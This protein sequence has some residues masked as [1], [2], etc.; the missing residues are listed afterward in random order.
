MQY[1]ESLLGTAIHGDVG[2]PDDPRR[3]IV[4][5]FRVLFDPS[6]NKEDIVHDLSTSEGL[7]KLK[8]GGISLKEG[9]K[10]K[11]RVSFVVQHE[12]IAGVKFVNKVKKAVFSD[13]EDIMIGSFA[14]SS[15]P[16]AFEF[17]KFNYREAPSGMLFRGNICNYIILYSYSCCVYS[18]HV[19]TDSFYYMY[20]YI[21]SIL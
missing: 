9:C 1:K 19:Y 18:A 6:E 10:Y 11:F 20:D 2:N 21:Y 8:T 16:Q 15:V 7:E 13:V 4:T 3:L 17:P 5:E 14:P 12:L